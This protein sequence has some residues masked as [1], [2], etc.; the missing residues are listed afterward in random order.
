MDARQELNARDSR[1]CQP[2]GL[3]RVAM[4]GWEDQVER[5]VDP[6]GS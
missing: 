4:C 1:I 5:M 3:T 2:I 6:D